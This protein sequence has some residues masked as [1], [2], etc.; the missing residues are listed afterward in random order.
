MNY[1]EI[2]EPLVR[3]KYWSSQY[4]AGFR[5]EV[6]KT[7]GKYIE[8]TPDRLSEVVANSRK[9]HIRPVVLVNCISDTWIP[10]CMEQLTAAGIHPLVLA[11]VNKK[12]SASA[13]SV[14]FD[15]YNVFYSLCGYLESAGRG[16]IAFLGLNP[17]SSND[18]L[19]REALADYYSISEAAAGRHIFP[20]HG[21]LEKCCGN[22]LRRAAEY[23]SVICSND[24]VAIKLVSFLKNHGISAPEDVY[25]ATIG[26]TFLSGIIAPKITVAEF[27]CFSIGREAARLY[28]F[29]S[30]KSGFFSVNATISG[31]ITVREST[32]GNPL[33]DP[34]SVFSNPKLP[35]N[36]YEDKDVKSI[37]SLESLFKNSD[38]TDKKILQGLLCDRKY[39]E[40]AEEFFISESSVKYRIKRMA[41]FAG[42]SS[43]AELLE[44]LARY[45]DSC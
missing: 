8:I 18:V 28:S 21:D 36:F 38:D 34:A 45:M 10:K 24:V 9:S 3:D 15:F 39:S 25:I 14:S 4:S 31:N 44:L 32:G 5:H 13:S 20:N 22:F 26:N 29:L 35:V 17:N 11:P 7:K 1:Y 37:I 30:K 16:K 42:C 23:N 41:G 43:R 12:P 19:K 27:D 2:I 6:Q 33:P 40:L